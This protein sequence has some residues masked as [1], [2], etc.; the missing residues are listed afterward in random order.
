MPDHFLL[1]ARH[2]EFYLSAEN[3]CIFTNILDLFFL[4]AGIW[5]MDWKHFY[6]LGSCFFSFVGQDECG[7]KSGATVPL[8]EA[9]PFWVYDSMLRKVQ[10]SLPWLAG[11]GTAPSFVG[12][13][14]LFLLILL[15]GG[16][17][18]QPRCL[19]H[20]RAPIMLG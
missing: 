2:C 9:K 3:F 17:F 7:V 20:N 19:P 4:F 8:I 12:A 5:L 10:R 15:G 13:Q 1:D 6:L 14:G 16:V 18:P 11:R